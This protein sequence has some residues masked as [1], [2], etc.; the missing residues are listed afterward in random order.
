MLVLLDECIERHR[1]TLVSWCDQKKHIQLFVLLQKRHNIL[2]MEHTF[3]RMFFTEKKFKLNSTPS[4]GKKHRYKPQRMIFRNVNFSQFVECH[5]SYCFDSR[6][7]ILVY[8]FQSRSVKDD[9]FPT[10]GHFQIQQDVAAILRGT[11]NESEL[12]NSELSTDCPLLTFRTAVAE[13]SSESNAAAR[14][15]MGQCH[16]LEFL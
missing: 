5:R 16:T 6:R 1:D 13:F 12:V 3:G 14:F 4:T 15:A 2:Q 8:S 9:H 11:L 7:F 10:L